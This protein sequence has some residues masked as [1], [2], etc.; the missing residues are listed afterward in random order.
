M[1][2]T[3]YGG[4]WDCLVL[5]GT[6]SRTLLNPPALSVGHYGTV[7]YSLGLPGI[8]WDSLGLSGTLYVGL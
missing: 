7:W 8:V 1:P 6:L 3:F 2:E 4:V 5:S